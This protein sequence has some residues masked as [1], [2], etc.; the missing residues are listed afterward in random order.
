MKRIVIDKTVVRGL[1]SLLNAVVRNGPTPE[2]GKASGFLED[3]VERFDEQGLEEHELTLEPRPTLEELVRG[4]VERHGPASFFGRVAAWTGARPV[5]GP[6]AQSAPTPESDALVASLRAQIAAMQKL[7]S[8]SAL[9]KKLAEAHQLLADRYDLIRKQE[10]Q[11]EAAKG[12]SARLKELE[13]Q[14]RLLTV[15][16]DLA[17]EFH[18]SEAWHARIREAD[19]RE[20]VRVLASKLAKELGG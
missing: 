7:H 20:L 18:E 13:E 16:R 12:E 1:R 19:D 9:E 15:D 14:L 8:E 2:V 10:A 3:L 4:H 5:E 17:R 6:M 11:L